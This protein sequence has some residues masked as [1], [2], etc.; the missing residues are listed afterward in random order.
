MADSS[1]SFQSS[2]LVLSPGASAAQITT[3]NNH[4]V[5]FPTGTI[6]TDLAVTGAADFVGDVVFHGNVALSQAP[7]MDLKLRQLTDVQI[8]GTDTTDRRLMRY[9]EILQKWVA[10]VTYSEAAEVS[11]LVRRTAAGGINAAN[12]NVSSSVT[13]DTI[14]ERTSDHGVT[15]DGVNLRDGIV[16]GAKIVTSSVESA[17]P[18]LTDLSLNGVTVSK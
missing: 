12:V 4:P 7:T 2:Q 8:S 15:A 10:D 18:A 13:T 17:N 16:T 14:T 6:T 5:S 9:D 1:V 3:S 11:T